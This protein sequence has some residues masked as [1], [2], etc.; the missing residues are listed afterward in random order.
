MR[1]TSFFTRETEN[2]GNRE[3]NI[4]SLDA[5]NLS[6]LK[7]L[8]DSTD[9]SSGD[10][11]EFELET[12]VCNIAEREPLLFREPNAT[13]NYW[14]LTE[15]NNLDSSKLVKLLE[16]TK[17]HNLELFKSSIS[18]AKDQIEK[19]QKL[20]I[21]GD[22]K[23]VDLLTNQKMENGMNCSNTKSN[24][25]NTKSNCYCSL[26]SDTMIIPA[27]AKPTWSK[28][29]NLAGEAM[30]NSTRMDFYKEALQQDLLEYWCLG[31]E[32]VPA[33]L[34]KI[35]DFR[36]EL[37]ATKVR[38]AQELMRLTIKHLELETT[39]CNDQSAAMKATAIGI[40][41]QVMPDEAQDIVTKANTGLDITIANISAN[42]YKDL[43][44]RRQKLQQAAP[45]FSDVVDPVVNISSHATKP[46]KEKDFPRGGRG[47]GGP[48]YWRSQG[49]R[50]PYARGRPE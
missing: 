10:I 1:I 48:R 29:R 26:Q 18:R 37:H 50:K 38:H 21:L 13:S 39:R 7:D 16:E 47:R 43:E 2:V 42:E 24:C 28:A 31:L 40:I 22:C 19:S 14:V 35:G 15:Q 3:A 5:R 36:Q 45:T 9:N 6:H 25:S 33:P 23:N 32:K 49:G 30:R 12:N 41:Q 4:N 11:S 17:K 27:A 8:N 34:M 46:K 44:K 20:T